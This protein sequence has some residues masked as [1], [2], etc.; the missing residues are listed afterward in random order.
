VQGRTLTADERAAERA[1]LTAVAAGLVRA[2]GRVACTL[3]RVGEAAGVSRMTPYTY[4]TDKEDLLD[5]VRADALAQLGDTT[6]AALAAGEDLPARLRGVGRAYVAF[7]LTEPEL[8]D[9]IYEA[10]PMSDAH[11][12]ATERYRRL[13]EAPL[14]EAGALG[15][16]ALPAERVGHALWAATHGLIALHRA[17][18]LRHGLD[19]EAVLQ[20]VG[21]VLA[22]GFLRRGE[23]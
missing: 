1:R 7:A 18:K 9:L 6:E 5:A 13:A 19:F 21:D 4:F 15:L 23:G 10:R 16:L 17:G 20:D 3:R 8:Y 12:A 2:E 11:R 14:Q 22:F